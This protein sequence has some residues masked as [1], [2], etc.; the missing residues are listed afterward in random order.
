MNV[1]KCR[2][3]GALASEEDLFCDQCGAALP[4]KEIDIPAQNSNSSL[5]PEENINSIKDKEGNIKSDDNPRNQESFS[6][7]NL[8]TSNAFKLHR[9]K[10]IV[11]VV[12]LLIIIVVFLLKS[13]YSKNN[14]L[15]GTTR[16]IGG[17][18]DDE[19][20][21]FSCSEES[22]TVNGIDTYPLIFDNE[23]IGRDQIKVGYQVF[24]EEGDL[25]RTFICWVRS[26]GDWIP[27]GS[28]EVYEAE[29]EH[30]NTFYMDP[31]LSFDALVITPE[32]YDEDEELIWTDEYTL[33][34]SGWE[35]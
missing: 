34:D 12:C 30:I 2:I 18:V 23:L 32:Y 26:D 6:Y 27:I 4:E 24:P 8:S 15:D 16:D 17:G 5:L 28:F 7:R 20:P 1:R 22:I 11:G 10:I 35:P 13:T 29:E 33:Y 19:I 31:P 3:C 9:T 14:L 25:T 21:D